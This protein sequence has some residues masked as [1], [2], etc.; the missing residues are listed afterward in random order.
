MS[1]FTNGFSK[2]ICHGKRVILS[3][4]MAHPHNFESAL[5]I[6]FEFCTVKEAERSYINTFPEKILVWDK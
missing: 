1:R 2:K 4:K 3:L 6:F 5:R